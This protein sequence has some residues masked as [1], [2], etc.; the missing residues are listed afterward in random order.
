MAGKNI[1]EAERCQVGKTKDGKY[2][3]WHKVLGKDSSPRYVD[4]DQ[5]VETIDELLEMYSKSKQ[6]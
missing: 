6:E 3:I 5:V 1:N 4:A 2:H